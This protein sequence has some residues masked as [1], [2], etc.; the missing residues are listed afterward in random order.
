MTRIVSIFLALASLLGVG[1]TSSAYLAKV[2]DEPITGEDLKREFI[3]MHGGH[4]KFLLGDSETRQFLGVVID[5]TLLTQEAERLDIQ[6]LPDIQKAVADFEERK[7]SELLVKTEIEDKTQPTPEEIK[8]AWQKE[9]TR[10][11]Q[12]RQIVLDTR[13]EAESVY[14]RLAL[15]EDFEALARSCSI[16]A[17]RIYG[18]RLPYLGWGA[19]EPA[20]EAV[21][22]QLQSPEISP[23]FA[24]K[25]GWEIVQIEDVQPVEPPAFDQ[26][27]RRIEG[28]LKRRKLDERRKAFS[29]FLWTKYHAH[30]ADVNLGPEGLHAA[31]KEK[32]DEPLVSW[33]GGSLTVKQF[34]EGTDW[35]ELAGLLPGRFRNEIEE[36]LRETVNGPLAAL[37][38]RARGLASDP[39]VAVPVRAY[40]DELMERVLY[41]DYVLKDVKVTDAEVDAYYA[42]HKA[43]YTSPEKRRVA[44][45]VVPTQQEAQEIKKRLDNGESF[46]ELVKAVSTDT[47]STKQAGDL[48]WI[49]KKDASGE[50]ANVFSF[51]DGQVS[52]P[53]KSK[54]GWH[55]IKVEAIAPAK[56][57]ALEDAREPIRKALMAQ[58]QRDARAVWVKKLREA[59]TIQISDAGIRQFLKSNAQ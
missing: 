2:N 56:P 31:L 42:A 9:T 25:D 19:M 10:L 26:A 24:T 6:N 18:G 54:F 16:A 1:C 37:E 52:E 28:I 41:A 22:F 39:Q 30:R 38:A 15:G 53:M 7:A 46:A 33:D 34:V 48:G 36:R 32:P 14:Q 20:W 13:E 35:K 50:F 23:V 4:G 21:V 43:D 5:Q 55:L 8:V 11:Y 57:M 29:E 40:R 58:K 27:A 59:A 49:T 44:Q 3:R 45:I 51:E 17:S 12:T 47:S